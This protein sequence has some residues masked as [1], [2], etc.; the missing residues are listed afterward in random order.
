MGENTM[1]NIPPPP[2][3]FTDDEKPAEIPPPPPGF[4]QDD[5]EQ[6][7]TVWD[8][9]T[10][11]WTTPVPGLSQGVDF[12]R[13]DVPNAIAQKVG[14]DM[15]MP[16]TGAALAGLTQASAELLPRTA[17]DVGLLATGPILKG[18]GKA[19]SKVGEIPSLIEKSAPGIAKG[20]RIAADAP[21][22]ILSEIV[23]HVSGSNPE[24]VKR[25]FNNP[26]AMGKFRDLI[27]QVEQ[28]ELVTTIKTHIDGLGSKI[29]EFENQYASFIERDINKMPLIV[30]TIDIAKNAGKKLIGEGFN[31]AKE[32]TGIAERLV[33]KIGS[34]AERAEV[35]K[36]LE[37]LHTPK[38]MGWGELKNIKTQLDDAINYVVGSGL[39]ARGEQADIAL[40]TVRTFV[41]EA[42]TNSLPK[43]KQGP[44]RAANAAYHDAMDAYN[45]LKTEIVGRTAGKTASK[46]L[47]RLKKGYQDIGVEEKASKIGEEALKAISDIQDQV[48]AGTFK[49]YIGSFGEGGFAKVLPT[50]PALFG[51]L[52]ALSGGTW[53]GAK[54][55][56]SQ[57]ARNPLA[58]AAGAEALFG[59]GAETRGQEPV[60]PV[61]KELPSRNPRFDIPIPSA[62]K[63]RKPESKK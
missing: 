15:N 51:A 47:S 32:I 42:L 33:D 63:A 60:A 11:A 19:L 45:E 61:D 41:S 10:K 43:D 59:T 9:I 26:G 27:G 35:A 12:L 58:S 1:K 17:G 23:A 18:T 24:A 62:I 34:P 4:T 13:E 29:K 49:K 6:P 30:N 7:Q 50:S 31:V 2:P 54:A 39:P 52:T 14:V 57:A 20:L 3:G 22:T 21:G 46:L 56:A 37:M 48:A 8:H 36:F 53:A 25:I 44:W 38:K 55:L 5:G 40:R 28:N 16:K